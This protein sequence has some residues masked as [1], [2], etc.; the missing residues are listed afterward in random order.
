MLKRIVCALGLVALAAGLALAA[1]ATTWT[2]PTFA[3]RK[4]GFRVEVPEVGLSVEETSKLYAGKPIAKLLPSENGLKAGWLRFFAPFDPVTTWMV[5][6]DMEHLDLVDDPYPASGSLADKR[7]TFLPYVFDAATCVENNEPI[8]YQLLVMPFVAPRRMCVRH[9]EDQSAFPWEAAWKLAG[10]GECC[11]KEQNINMI[12]YKHKAVELKKNQG[13]WR[14]APL[15]PEFRKTDADRMRTDVIYYVDSH[16]GGDLGEIEFVVNKATSTALPTL[17][18][19]VIFHGKSW[20]THL[21]RHHGGGQ[22]LADYQAWRAA[23]QAW[24]EKK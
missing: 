16:P 19:N 11:K 21:N 6:T 15:P 18:D 24:I 17:M 7:R 4:G 5:I 13:A 1:K 20:E 14:I 9:D 3:E 8:M 10:M 22:A 2:A 12:E 23:Y